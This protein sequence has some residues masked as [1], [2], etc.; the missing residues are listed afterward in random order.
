MKR[1]RDSLAYMNVKGA[2][3]VHFGSVKNMNSSNVHIFNSNK[4]V[5]TF[6]GKGLYTFSKNETREV[7]DAL[8]YTEKQPDKNSTLYFF[9]ND[10]MIADPYSKLKGTIADTNTIK[11]IT[12]FFNQG[13]SRL[14]GSKK[15]NL[16]DVA[17]LM[18]KNPKLKIDIVARN[19][20]RGPLEYNQKLSRDRANSIKSYL[21][22]QGCDNKRIKTFAV[23]EKAKVSESLDDLGKRAFRR[24]DLI[25]HE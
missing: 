21:V 25:L 18:I 13:E 5:N 23:M 10:N 9:E 20:G 22:S 6:Y 4:E 17:E 15:I 24:A 2:F 8:P 1:T 3:V 16:E 11:V 12:V 7:I 19:D 14:S